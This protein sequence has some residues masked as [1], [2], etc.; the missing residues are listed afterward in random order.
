MRIIGPPGYKPE[1]AYTSDA[2]TC[3]IL[4]ERRL[5]DVRRHARRQARWAREAQLWC[6]ACGDDLKT[7]YNRRWACQ[8]CLGEMV[9]WPAQVPK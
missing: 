3:R 1:P 9:V 5:A 2:E 4:H 7:R 8:H 6:P